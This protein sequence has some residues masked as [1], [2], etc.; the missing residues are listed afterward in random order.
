[1]SSLFRSSSSGLSTPSRFGAS[2]RTYLQSSIPHRNPRQREIWEMQSAHQNRLNYLHFKARL[3]GKYAV[4]DE[5][6]DSEEPLP[7]PKLLDE[8]RELTETLKQERKLLDE[9]KEGV[10]SEID[11]CKE[12]LE[13]F[14]VQRA[15][16]LE[17]KRTENATRKKLYQDE[18]A[19]LKATIAKEKAEINV[20]IRQVDFR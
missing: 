7:D 5:S 20:S 8:E 1:M 3:D 15:K 18:L 13:K 14:R 16:K 11:K 10:E 4:Y 6:S 2:T 12:M 19:R 17:A 9:A